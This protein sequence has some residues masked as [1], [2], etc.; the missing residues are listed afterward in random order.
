MKL[1]RRLALA[2]NQPIQTQAATF[3]KA[4]AFP[5]IPLSSS[6]TSLSQLG[7]ALPPQPLTNN[8]LPY[9]P[10]TS[11]TIL[12]TLLHTT[13]FS[14]PFLRTLVPSIGL[15]YALQAATAVPSILAQTERFYDLSGSITYISCVGLSLYLP[16]LRVRYAA[17]AA[18]KAAPALPSLLAALR[19]GSQGVPGALNWRQVVLSAAVSFW[20]ARCEFCT[21]FKS[22]HS[23]ERSNR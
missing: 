9:H 2:C 6:R 22:H 3:H 19:G 17:T 10:S 8:L 5:G 1:D 16:A 15:A 7:F 4:I 14:T 11:M 13:N 21:P 20:A 18:G 12:S 23:A